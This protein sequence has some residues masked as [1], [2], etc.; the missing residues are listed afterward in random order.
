MS[1]DWGVRVGQSRDALVVYPLSPGSDDANLKS[2]ER[3]LDSTPAKPRNCDPT[4][5]P[6]RAS[7]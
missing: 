6:K 5:K 1:Y 4:A 2:A 3:G 7:A